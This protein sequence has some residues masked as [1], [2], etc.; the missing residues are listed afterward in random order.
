MYY[1][2]MCTALADTVTNT[3]VNDSKSPPFQGLSIQQGDAIH[4]HGMEQGRRKVRV[5]TRL[6]EEIRTCQC[7]K[8]ELT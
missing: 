7:G 4:P 1:T 3:N 6:R 8:T 2:Q 5:V